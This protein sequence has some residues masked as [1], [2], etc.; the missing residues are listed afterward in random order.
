MRTQEWGQRRTKR[1][2]H[3][4]LTEDGNSLLVPDALKGNTFI[5]YYV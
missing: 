1:T 5:Y 2:K 4:A 3:G